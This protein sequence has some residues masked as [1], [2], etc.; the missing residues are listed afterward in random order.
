MSDKVNGSKDS[1]V[2]AV[3]GID[4]R[5]PG[6]AS[7]ASAPAMAAWKSARGKAVADL[8]AVAKQVGAMDDFPEAAQAMILLRAI[9]ANLT[10]EPATPQ[11]V[12]E[13]QRYIESD[14]IID[15][16]EEPNGFGIEIALKAPLLAALAGLSGVS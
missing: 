4:V 10:E 5:N 14:D 7:A 9:A 1:W 12:A 2:L 16:A 15:E 6:T 13:L 8:H 11:Q 3:L